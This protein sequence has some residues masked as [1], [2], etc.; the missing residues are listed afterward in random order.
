MAS[1]DTLLFFRPSDAE[2][3]DDDAAVVNYL[4]TA[5]ADEPD[6]LLMTV[7]H[8][9]TTNSFMY[10]TGFLPRNYAGGGLT[11]TV[12]WFSDA[13]TTGDAKLEIGIKSL[14]DTDSVDKAAA[15]A[16]SATDTTNGT[17]KT[18]NYTT[19]TFTS[20]AQMDSLAA[21]EMFQLRMNADAVDAAHTISGDVRVVG[22]EI[23]ET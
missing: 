17:A 12:M 2:P 14:G 23:K 22:I 6:A 10:Y 15:T 8:N 1:G 5:S 9:D 11:A 21:G 19:I 16:Q 4:L 20:G 7:D 13:A 18:L 3:P